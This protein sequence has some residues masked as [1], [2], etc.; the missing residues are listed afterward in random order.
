[1]YLVLGE[2]LEGLFGKHSYNPAL[3]WYIGGIRVGF[4]RT[5]GQAGPEISNENESS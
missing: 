4:H 1:M 3:T 2:S 5:K